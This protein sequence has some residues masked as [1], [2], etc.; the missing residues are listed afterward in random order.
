MLRTEAPW[1]RECR[2]KLRCYIKK[3]GR[4][5]GGTRLLVTTLADREVTVSGD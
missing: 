5:R 4:E 1:G 2:T 3:L